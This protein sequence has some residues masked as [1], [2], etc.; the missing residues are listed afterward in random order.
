MEFKDPVLYPQ[1]AQK[2]IDNDVSQN[3]ISEN[4]R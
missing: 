2:Y 1:F 3:I 4:I